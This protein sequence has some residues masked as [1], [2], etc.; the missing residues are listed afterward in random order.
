[1]NTAGI[2]FPIFTDEVTEHCLCVRPEV[3][4]QQLDLSEFTT[5]DQLRRLCLFLRPISLRLQNCTRVSDTGLSYVRSMPL[6]H[7][8]LAYCDLITDE[9]LAHLKGMNLDRLDLS[10]CSLVTDAG[11]VHLH[12]MPLKKLKL[13]NC[14]NITD[15][16]LAHLIGM[17]LEV[18][19]L[20]NCASIT[21]NGLAYLKGMPL[22]VLKLSHCNLISEEGL[23][24]LKEMPLRI[25]HLDSWQQK[26]YLTG[27][28]WTDTSPA[29]C[30][31]LDRKGFTFTSGME[32]ILSKGPCDGVYVDRCNDRVRVAWMKD[33]LGSDHVL[34][35][36]RRKNEAF[37]R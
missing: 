6:R 36:F 11:L 26:V 37:A 7:L 15:K 5:D 34:V 20:S 33:R 25:L 29:V 19:D 35:L 4:K 24:H 28:R 18:L 9:G 8:D 17:P 30:S 10:H 21:N 16:G 27:E 23:G 13:S 1:M 14:R 12:G 32:A 3:W 2:P 22:E 31:Y